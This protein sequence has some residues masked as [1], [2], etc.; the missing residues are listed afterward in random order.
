MIAFAFMFSAFAVG[1]TVGLI[2]F[3]F[4][5]SSNVGKVILAIAFLIFVLYSIG[6]FFDRY[7]TM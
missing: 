4:I 3:S 1:I 5:I 6:E 7:N 2:G